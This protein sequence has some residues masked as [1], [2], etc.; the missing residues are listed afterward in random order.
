MKKAIVLYSGGL[1]SML[2]IGLMQRAGV[3]VIPVMF[4]TP[5]HNPYSK[6]G[7]INYGKVVQ[8][9][10]SVTLR[11]V[12]LTDDLLDVIR[13]PKHG[14]GKNINPCID[15]HL[16]MLQTAKQLMQTWQA[17][18]IV[19]GEV[20]GQRP[21]SQHKQALDLIARKSGLDGLV[22]RPLSAKLL[23]PTI[24]QTEGWVAEEFLL[25]IG[26]RGRKRQ[27]ALAQEWGLQDY[28][29]PAGG[30]L[31]TDSGYSRKLKNLLESD[32]LDIENCHWI[33]LG[34]FFNL[35]EKCKLVVA[36]NEKECKLLVKHSRT[37][38]YIIE[39][40][41]G[42]GPTALLRGVG[43]EDHAGLA[44]AI[45]AYYCKHDGPLDLVIKH[46]QAPERIVTV[47]AADE[48]EVKQWLVM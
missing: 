45:V 41:E 24:P 1:D 23:P 39:P 22:V 34:R 44:N 9:Q 43:S 35:S 3:E 31:L 12:P 17:D 26:G 48:A 5:F 25:D 36:R 18:F 19:T 20:L 8:D 2:V 4:Q 21:M 33:Q 7:M 30:C 38:D 6:S 47:A 27:M 16:L 32:M 14:R 11:E 28:S 37:E 15:C 29:T 40:R 42:K 46:G 10:F 13:D